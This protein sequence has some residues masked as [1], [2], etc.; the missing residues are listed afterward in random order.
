MSS[1]R[2]EVKVGTAERED[3]FN[4]LTGVTDVD[5]DDGEVLLVE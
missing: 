4:L 2:N 5:E 3:E 1:E